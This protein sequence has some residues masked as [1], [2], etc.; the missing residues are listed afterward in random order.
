M[1]AMEII[2]MQRRQQLLIQQQQQQ[3][4]EMKQR[5]D[6]QRALVAQLARQDADV[7]EAEI[8]TQRQRLHH[9]QRQEQGVQRETN[10]LLDVSAKRPVKFNIEPNSDEGSGVGSN[11]KN[12]SEVSGTERL[13]SLVDPIVNG[14]RQPHQL[15][16]IQQQHTVAPH[17]H[18]VPRHHLAPHHHP[19]PHH[20][21]QLKSEKQVERQ[22]IREE[23]AER[24]LQ[25]EE[26]GK[27]RDHSNPNPNTK[28][29]THETLN[30]VSSALAAKVKHTLADPL[31]PGQ[32]KRTIVLTTSESEYEHS[33]DDGSWSSEEMGSEDEEVSFYLL[34]YISFYFIRMELDFSLFFIIGRAKTGATEAGSV[35][36]SATTAT[37]S[38]TTPAASISCSAYTLI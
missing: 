17:H 35:V 38:T 15:G 19:E 22:I 2:Q 8:R 24:Q 31:L 30:M 11:S 25:K 10:G 29:S 16:I 12:G 34:R 33:D 37:A 20:Y 18:P 28:H 4:L 23:V 32:H 5:E 9:E 26:K 6:E 1:I 21:Q 3:Q 14:I 13:I 36:G 27:R 7:R